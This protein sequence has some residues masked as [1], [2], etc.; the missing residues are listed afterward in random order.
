MYKLDDI[1]IQFFGAAGTVT[2][3]KHLLTLG[4]HKILIDCGLFQGEN[5]DLLNNKP[6]PIPPGEIDVVLLTHAHLDHTG[7]L[8]VIVKQGFKGK[9]KGTAPTLHIA[10]IILYDC[11]KITEEENRQKKK[12]T[13][14]KRNDNENDDW[15]YNQMEVLNTVHRFSA[16]E[17]D[18]WLKLFEDVNI[19]YRN[20]SHILGACFIEIKYKDKMLVFS[21]DIGRKNDQLLHAPQQPESADILVMESTYGNRLHPQNTDE[22]LAD[23]INEASRKNGTI[24]IPSFAVERFQLLMYKLWKLRSKNK[25]PNLPIYMDSPMGNKVMEIFRNNTS[26]HK[27]HISEMEKM[28]QDVHSID[29]IEDTFRVIDNKSP[30]IV[31]AGSGM[32]SGGRVMTY[33]QYYLS[34]PETTVLLVG[35]QA[36]GT[37]GRLL[38]EGANE[39]MIRDEVYKVNAD[40]KFVNG[41]SSH[42]DQAELLDWMQPIAQQAQKVFLVHGEPEAAE[43]LKEQ[44][45]LKYNLQA[46]IAQ[47]DE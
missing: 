25:I 12:R 44:I 19:R 27:L 35:Y 38:Y 14:Q 37:I 4:S 23:L 24:I 34:V 13:G 33:L 18:T 40:I 20:N 5:E 10:E 28:L 21:G 46:E 11:A 8:P 47:R 31:V 43:V 30:K 15:R 17:T 45:Q 6:L 7:Y 16:I 41:L 32:V 26:W 36:E 3:S 22:I 39:I 42:A 2:G 29:E 1:T 9:I